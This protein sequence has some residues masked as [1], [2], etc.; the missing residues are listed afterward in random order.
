MDKFLGADSVAKP[1]C[2]DRCGNISIPFPFGTTQDCYGNYDFFLSCNQTSHPPQLFLQDTNIE[3]TN[4]SLDGQLTVLPYFARAC[5]APNGTRGGQDAMIKFPGSQFT[6]N[7]T[8]NKLT[9][10]GCDAYA[11]IS[12]QRLNRPDYATGCMALCKRED[13]LVE[14]SCN[15]VGCCQLADIPKDI[16]MVQ[17]EMKRFVNYTNFSGFDDCNYAFLAEETVFSFSRHSVAS[18]KNITRLPM[19]A[20]WAI[21]NMTCEEAKK[22]SS[23]YACKSLNSTCYEPK[24]GTGY[25]CRC[26][27]GYAGNPYLIDG[28]QDIDE[29]ELGKCRHDCRNTNGSFTCLCPKGYHGDGENCSPCVSLIVILVAG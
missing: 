25:R 17:I 26:E 10:V 1:N 19:V 6:V 4:I 24:N 14:G 27:P 23:G 18:L 29:C 8:A 16:W 15:G 20:D 3:I 21:G 22:N 13:D 12:G 11:Y 2:T 5:Y 28:C 9:I 7:N